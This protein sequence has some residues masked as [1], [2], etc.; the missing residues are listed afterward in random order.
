MS[1]GAEA[2]TLVRTEQAAP[3]RIGARRRWHRRLW[4]SPSLVALALGAAAWEAVGWIAGFA[5]FPPLSRVV[6]RLGELTAD[7][8]IIGN[9]AVSLS[10]LLIGFLIC[11]VL[12][13]PIGLLMG[14]SRRLHHALDVYVHALLTAPSLVFAPI[15]FSVFGLS[16][17]AVVAVI[18]TYS[19]FIIIASSEGAVAAV[20]E[21][22]VEMAT[23]YGASRRQ[24]FWQ[25]VV[26]A[27]L[28]LVFAGLRIGAGRAVKGMINGEMFIAAVGLG[29]IIINAGRRFDATTVL[30]ILLVTI[31]TALIVS[32]GLQA[33]DRRV[34]AWLPDTQ[35][36]RL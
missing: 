6:A 16:R 13:V 21:S 24:V 28:P 5:Y 3:D 15:F 30:A 1:E 12:G 35:R 18:V 27:S 19:L 8:E 14:V 34:T 2:R 26:P 10:N 25:I 33:L 31:A 32:A 7:G 17:W 23:A 4:T 29:A 22:L 9:L 11:V 36:T 20:D